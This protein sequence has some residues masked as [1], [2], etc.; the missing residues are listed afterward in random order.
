MPPS[1]LVVSS[2]LPAAMTATGAL[3]TLSLIELLPTEVIEEIMKAMRPTELAKLALA[4][5][6]LLAVFLE[7]QSIILTEVLSKQPEFKTM[8]L[9]ATTTERDFQLGRMLYPRTITLDSKASG[10]DP[11]TDQSKDIVL[12]KSN[13]EEDPNFMPIRMQTRD[14]V[15]VWRS[16]KVVD[17]YVDMY[18]TIRWRD[19]PEQRRCL[20][21]DEEARL[22]K[23][24]ARWYLYTIHFQANRR[25]DLYKPKKWA[26]D[27]RLHHI[28]LMP[29]REILELQDFWG[30]IYDL[31]SQDLCSSVEQLDPEVRSSFSSDNA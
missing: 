24:I 29:T 27:N 26:N 19:Q 11:S 17:W 28:R 13:M 14:L 9:V 25:R 10:F 31:V 6:R 8:L 21:P 22:R 7:A 12:L 2:D 4:S 16:L 15:R 20:R 18:P 30:V 5:K 23:A 3:E 1:T